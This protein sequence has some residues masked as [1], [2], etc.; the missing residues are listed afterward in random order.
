MLCAA[1]TNGK[2]KF[3]VKCCSPPIG[4]INE[5][6]SSVGR[7]EPRFE[8]WI[9]K[10]IGRHFTVF[11]QSQLLIFDQGKSELRKEGHPCHPVEDSEQIGYIY[12]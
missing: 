5:F 1:Q 7:E 3:V 4:N 10:Q 8:D 11:C 2:P 6:V 9:I 12:G